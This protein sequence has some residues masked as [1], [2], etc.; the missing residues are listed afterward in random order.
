MSFRRIAGWISSTFL[1]SC[2]K[3]RLCGMQFNPVFDC[4]GGQTW[5]NRDIE[6]MFYF[7]FKGRLT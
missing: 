4:K 1:F 7:A 3:Y 5:Y 2:K 6:Q